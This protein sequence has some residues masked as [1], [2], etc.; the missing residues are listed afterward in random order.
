MAVK[1]FNGF[2]MIDGFIKYPYVPECLL[3]NDE[4]L[5]AVYHH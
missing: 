2:L 4:W 3:T 5:A 1:S